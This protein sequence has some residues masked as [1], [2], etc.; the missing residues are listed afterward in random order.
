[1]RA[2]RRAAPDRTKKVNA[3]LAAWTRSTREPAMHVRERV[4]V[5]AER[6]EMSL[7]DSSDGCARKTSPGFNW[8]SLR[9]SSQEPAFTGH[10]TSDTVKLA[11]SVIVT[12]IVDILLVRA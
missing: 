11:P 9:T 12:V 8:I 5:V 4:A 10:R 2:R 6:S 3:D 1:M 7:R